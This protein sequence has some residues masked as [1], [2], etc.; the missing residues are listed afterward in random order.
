MEDIAGGLEAF[1]DHFVSEIGLVSRE[2][3]IADDQTEKLNQD[4][5]RKQLS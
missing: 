4:F 5:L 1:R 3:N 2:Y